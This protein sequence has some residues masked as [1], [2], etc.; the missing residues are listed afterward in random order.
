MKI[1][2]KT[3]ITLSLV[4]TIIG[5][6]LW[7]SRIHFIAE[8]AAT[9]AKEAVVDQKRYLIDFTE[10]KN[11]VKWIKRKLGGNDSADNSQ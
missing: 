3:T 1:D 9:M 2:E 8:S 11:D 6:V 4:L 7:L 10:V 5:A